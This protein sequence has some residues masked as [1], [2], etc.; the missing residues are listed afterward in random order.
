MQHQSSP[1]PTVAINESKSPVPSVRVDAA[2]LSES[3]SDD[4]DGGH[5]DKRR[6]DDDALP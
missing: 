3:S 4:D 5:Y 6:D 1:T 2:M